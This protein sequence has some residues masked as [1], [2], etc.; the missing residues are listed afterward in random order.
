MALRRQAAGGS[1][2]QQTPQE[3][4]SLRLAWEDTEDLAA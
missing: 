3:I 2:D 4:A 1:P